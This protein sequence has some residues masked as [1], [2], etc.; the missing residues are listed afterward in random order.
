MVDMAISTTRTI[1]TIIGSSR[2][3]QEPTS[4]TLNRAMHQHGAAIK[5]HNGHLLLM[6]MSQ[7][8]V[9]TYTYFYALESRVSINH[10]TFSTKDFWRHVE[11]TYKPPRTAIVRPVAPIQPVTRT[12][13]KPDLDNLLDLNSLFSPDDLN[14][15][16]V[17]NMDDIGKFKIAT[18]K[19]I[20][21]KDVHLY[22][23]ILTSA[24]KGVVQASARN[25][26]QG[27]ALAC[28]FLYLLPLIL[29]R[30]PDAAVPQRLD[31]FLAGDLKF[32]TRGLLS[33]QDN[34]INKGDRA[35]TTT[36]HRQAAARVF[37]GQYAKAVQVLIH[38]DSS[39][40]Y[41]ERKEAMDSK[42]PK[43]TA[44]DDTHIKSLP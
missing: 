10:R 32:C 23:R 31:A 13:A 11:S 2:F 35:P 19:N 33:V 9:V 25:D 36:K 12:F 28:R 8:R 14:Y 39:T 20:K 22:R 37:D 17:F 15:I 18:I 21:T 43:R 44:E 1:R 16:K 3:Q 30:K 38:E 4:F 24:Y 42:H 40:T 5:V 26:H 41:E 29:L 6:S 34:Y 7:D 27:L